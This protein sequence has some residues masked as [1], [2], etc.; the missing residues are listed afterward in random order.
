[1]EMDLVVGDCQKGKAYHP[2]VMSESD[3]TSESEVDELIRSTRGERAARSRK[4]KV[5][6]PLSVTPMRRRKKKKGSH[7]KKREL[8]YDDVYNYENGPDYRWPLHNVNVAPEH[9]KEEYT[10]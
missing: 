7:G 9:L 8:V 5:S 2:D 4:R 1:M 10:W 6:K 3:A